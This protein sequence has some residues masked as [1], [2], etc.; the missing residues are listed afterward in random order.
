MGLIYA[1]RPPDL[2]GDGAPGSSPGHRARQPPGAPGSSRVVG[3][4]LKITD[5]GASARIL[6]LPRP[7]TLLEHLGFE[8]VGVTAPLPASALGLLRQFPHD[9]TRE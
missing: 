6:R 8:L 7:G 9:V 4:G 3:C 1:R 5:A 2:G